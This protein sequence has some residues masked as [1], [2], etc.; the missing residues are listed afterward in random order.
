MPSRNPPKVI[1]L[2]LLLS[3]PVVLY[4]AAFILLRPHTFTPNPLSFLWRGHNFYA[5]VDYVYSAHALSE[6]DGFPAAQ[7]FMNLIESAL[8]IL[9]LYLYSSTGAGSA[10]GL[11]VG[12]A[13]VV[14]TLSKTMLYLLNEVFA[15]GRHVLH[16][17]LSTFIWCYAVPSS[18]WI[19]FPAWCTVWF[20]G[21]IL[22][23]I[24]EGEGSGKGGKEKKRV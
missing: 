2:W 7:S 20:G 19:L 23:R 1:L 16:N 17:D 3:T 11:V 22:R 5:T 12:F 13:A 15:G 10:G 4:D 24:D 18:L 21:E 6:Q 14:M 9:Y 8:N